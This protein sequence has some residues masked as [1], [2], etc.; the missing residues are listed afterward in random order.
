MRGVSTDMC[1]KLD[2]A[3]RSTDVLIAAISRDFPCSVLHHSSADSIYYLAPRGAALGPP[4]PSLT[5]LSTTRATVGGSDLRKSLL[6][7]NRAAAPRSAA[8]VHG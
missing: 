7:H 6:P 3:V 8:S 5:P 4:G 1:V 2:G